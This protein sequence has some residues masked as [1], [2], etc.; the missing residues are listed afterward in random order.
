[1]YSKISTCPS[2]SFSVFSVHWRKTSPVDRRFPKPQCDALFHNT[3]QTSIHSWWR[4][5]RSRI[6]R[7]WTTWYIIRE[8]IE[9]GISSVYCMLAWVG[10]RG[11][12]CRV[13][14]EVDV[15]AVNSWIYGVWRARCKL[16]QGEGGLYTRVTPEVVCVQQADVRSESS[17]SF[18]QAEFRPHCQP[19]LY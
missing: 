5:F 7:Q 19:L 11:Y 16:V 14:Q 4:R 15:R 17:Q 2:S 13:E 6:N 10:S 18:Q 1:M 12:T 8:S 9:F 3:A